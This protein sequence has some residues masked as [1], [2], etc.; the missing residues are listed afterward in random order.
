[1]RMTSPFN[2]TG[3][4]ALPLPFAMTSSGLPISVQLVGRLNDEATILP[5]GAFLERASGSKERHP[6]L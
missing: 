5:L 2:L 1:M 4:P 3:H 6:Q